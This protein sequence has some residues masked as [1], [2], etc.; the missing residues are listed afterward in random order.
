MFT[1]PVMT[2]DNHTSGWH[3]A[4]KRNNFR[5]LLEVSVILENG[6]YTTLL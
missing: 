3:F 5:N 4:Y 1:L 2:A 6:L